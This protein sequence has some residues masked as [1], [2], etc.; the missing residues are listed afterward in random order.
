MQWNPPPT[1]SAM[2][3]PPPYSPA[4]PYPGASYSF[5]A[6][7]RP[8]NGTHSTENGI[9]G[10]NANSAQENVDEPLLESVK[11]SPSPHPVVEQKPF[12]QT[13][14]CYATPKGSP[15][16]YEVRWISRVIWERK[17]WC[18]HSGWTEYFAVA[19]APTEHRLWAGRWQYQ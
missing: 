18:S 19:K 4:P 1:S 2:L 13:S 8:P 15:T 12:F 7:F 16:N 9:S 11:S 17:F 14:T 5:T 10:A 6:D 3:C